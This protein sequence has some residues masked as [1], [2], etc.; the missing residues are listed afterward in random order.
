MP[1]LCF[2]QFTGLKMTAVAWVWLRMKSVAR[3]SRKPRMLL[4]SSHRMT[5]TPDSE[6]R[7]TSGW[8]QDAYHQAISHC[9]LPQTRPPGPAVP[10]EDTRV[11]KHRTPA[12]DTVV[13]AYQIN[14]FN[15]PR[16]LHF[17]IHRKA[18]NSLRYLV[19]FLPSF[20]SFI[21]LPLS[22]FCCFLGLHLPG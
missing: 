10:P 19:F 2:P 7:G 11:G 8:K 15:E 5:T 12:Q 20:L 1:A 6:P 21:F 18:L 3:N 17:P 13:H 9:S 4:P 14:D 22:F 16:L